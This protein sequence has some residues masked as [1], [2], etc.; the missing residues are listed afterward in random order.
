MRDGAKGP[1]RVAV[2]KPR[3]GVRTPRRPH[4]HEEMVVVRRS[5]A[6]DNP[7]VVKVEVSLSKAAP[8]PPRGECAR[9][10]QAEHRLEECLQRSKSEAGLAADEVRHWR[11]GHHHPTWFL[12]TET[13][14]GKQL[15][16][17]DDVTAETGR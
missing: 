12:V 6:R 8:E 7:Q 2:V 9:V 11:G 14:R 16:A 10:A 5:R 17:C 1:L 3:V 15:D 4:G 13:L